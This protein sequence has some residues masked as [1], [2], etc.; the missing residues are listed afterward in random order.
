[1]GMHRLGFGP[2]WCRP[3]VGEHFL[4]LVREVYA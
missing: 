1:M 2:E 4:S 3:P